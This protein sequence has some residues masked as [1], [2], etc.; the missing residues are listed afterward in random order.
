MKKTL[1]AVLCILAA[2][3][4][5]AQL[6]QTGTG[7]QSVQK[8]T[9]LNDGSYS[10]TGA[11]STEKNGRIL[12]GGADGTAVTVTPGS[13][14]PEKTGSVVT[15]HIKFHF[16]IHPNN[17]MFNGVDTF[18][19]DLGYMTWTNDLLLEADMPDGYYDII[20]LYHNGTGLYRK[21]VFSKNFHVYK[22]MDTTILV[23][24]A[25]HM[26]TLKLQDESGNILPRTTG[27]GENSGVT[28]EFPANRKL[29]HRSEIFIGYPDTLYLS[30]FTPDIKIDISRAMVKKMSQTA[31]HRYHR[32]IVSYPVLNGLTG[33]VTLEN[34]PSDYTLFPT[35]FHSSPALNFPVLSF[36]LA[37]IVNT[38]FTPRDYFGFGATNG[39]YPSHAID[40]CMLYAADH[41]IDTNVVFFSNITYHWEQNP[42]SPNTNLN[43]MIA[44][45]FTYL[46]N[47]NNLVASA[48]G[49]Y[50]SV[51]ADYIAPSGHPLSSGNTAPFSFT[52]SSNSGSG[53]IINV[54]WV[55][56]AGQANESRIIDN[57]RSTYDIWRGSQRLYHDSL[58]TGAIFYPTSVLTPYK[59]NIYDS[60]YTLLG[61]PGTLKT[62]LDFDLARNDANPPELS[63][64]KIL[65]VNEIST[66]LVHGFDASVSLTGG[67]F[68]LNDLALPVYHPMKEMAL[69]YRNTTDTGWIALTV[70]PH[71]TVWDP[72]NGM[73]FTADLAP[74]LDHFP[75]S[76]WVDLKVV[77]TD[78]SENTSME[79]M[80]PAFLVRDKI[81]GLPKADGTSTLRIYPNPAREIIHIS[82]IDDPAEITV[83][84]SAGQPVIEDRNTKEIDVSALK[85]G[86]YIVRARN[87]S[88]GANLFGRFIK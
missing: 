2:F 50:P 73:L 18:F 42:A 75:D 57:I 67:D 63:S 41:A 11:Y 87:G 24:S 61:R 74:V 35:I 30:D 23:T 59:V 14:A 13:P 34:T 47:M 68:V 88:T 1:L 15:H 38:A 39:D 56:I 83:Y 28:F 52:L 27:S 44:G 26:M 19:F 33:N 62:T 4:A 10:F 80:H 60:N 85:P 21:Y 82:G 16:D 32:Y 6:L 45:T 43:A 40:T 86:L 36:G 70:V 29:R 53:Q 37:F 64:M 77:M 7:I 9:R 54:P 76:A 31:D 71:P 55:T 72:D 84:S 22:N 48:S 51:A 25:T 8:I 17:V 65:K 81:T 78:S 79:I 5:N 3:A 58:I 66:E 12:A 49:R 20:S 69:F 46:D